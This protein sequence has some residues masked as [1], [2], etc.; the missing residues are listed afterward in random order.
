M[1]K[2]SFKR[3]SI[4]FKII[5]PV[6]ILVCLLF[7]VIYI[8]LIIFVNTVIVKK[9]VLDVQT[10]LEVRNERVT[11]AFNDYSNIGNMIELTNAE[12]LDFLIKN[13]I[14]PSTINELED[15]KKI[16]LVTE[17]TQSIVNMLKRNTATDAF[18]FLDGGSEEDKIGI[19]LRTSN[20]TEYFSD[21]ADIAVE[22]SPYS[23]CDKL[24]SSG[25]GVSQFYETRLSSKLGT[26]LFEKTKEAF[27]A[28]PT[29]QPSLLGY[30][31][32]D[33]YAHENKNFEQAIVKTYPLIIE[34]VYYGVIGVGFT[35]AFCRQLLSLSD[36][37][38]ATNAAYAILNKTGEAFKP[39]ASL[40][41]FSSNTSGEISKYELSKSMYD[42]TLALKYDN[43]DFYAIMSPIKLY[44]DNSP[45]EDEEFFLA[46][47]LDKSFF[48]LNSNSVIRV[49]TFVFV[50]TFLMMLVILLYIS[51]RFVKPIISLTSS[52]R[53]SQALN[54]Y[55]VGIDE[56]DV[57]LAK[58]KNLV[59]YNNDGYEKMRS[60]FETF[61]NEIAIFDYNVVTEKVR[62]FGDFFGIIG[63]DLN[64]IPKEEI[65]V[66]VFRRLIEK[67]A[68]YIF[69]QNNEGDRNSVI[70]KVEEGFGK[71]KYTQ[72]VYIA[73]N[74]GTVGVA[75]DVT[76][77]YQSIETAKIESGIDPLT[78]LL[79]RRGF[80]RVALA[81]QDCDDI[82][83]GAIVMIDLDYLK[84]YND[85]YGH[86]FGDHYIIQF[87]DALNRLKTKK[88]DVV[89]ISGDEFILFYHHYDSME[90][91]KADIT[92]AKE[93][94][95][96]GIVISF[97]D[98]VVTAQSSA[99]VAYYTDRLR[100]Y[101]QL[102]SYADFAMYQ[103]KSKRR[104]RMMEFNKKDYEDNLVV[105]SKIKQ[106]H[107]LLDEELI[108][109]VFQP[110]VSVRTG[111]VLGY[112]ALM[113][114]KIEEIKTPLEILEYAKN[115][116]RLTDLENICITKA[117]KEYSK[118]NCDKPVFINSIASAIISKEIRK[119]I[120]NSLKAER[121]RVIIEM[122][123]EE[124]SSKETIEEKEAI[125]RE[126]GFEYAID[127]YGVG[128]SN[129][130]ALMDMNPT[131]I[132][133]DISLV[134]HVNDS[135]K[136]R[137]IINFLVDF[138]LQN[139]IKLIAEGV[140]NIEQVYELFRL[141]VEYIQG[142]LIAIP[143]Q[144]LKLCPLDLKN[145]I[146]EINSKE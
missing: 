23:V 71:Y 127:D 103:A 56:I 89:H 116:N 34:G 37:P 85:Q 79:N 59:Q 46:I 131:Y 35:S 74:L 24:A 19:Y 119:E 143:S 78:G 15:E 52:V 134:K 104:E 76:N 139:N 18:L 126:Y 84:R 49:L 113:R 129:L 58:I 17:H 96:K 51:R 121:F 5:F 48:H 93:M 94:L 33:Y 22:I 47:V 29:S 54:Y 20:P 14:E 82:Q 25:Y 140:E 10:T 30:W 145:K 28:Y 101:E 12:T 108:Y 21:N 125:M 115:Q 105:L 146:I 107:K 100:D 26:N 142:Y 132:K 9:D 6:F 16:Q 42:N 4:F 69:E 27:K 98:I 57:L 67:R 133:I 44:T 118:L 41:S 60:I 7:V 88:C 38:N 91:L 43:M 31:S 92:V 62:L 77:E 83:N 111:E 81:V 99:G 3:N 130:K 141:G 110:I 109:F 39:I 144:D 114:S 138:S 55:S 66:I 72:L 136:V 137:S 50:P 135:E 68:S 40:S 106:I 120:A 124:L 80:E 11:T 61:S 112:E 86:L 36:Y 65:D 75:T 123:E 32:T 70:Y 117:I 102:V 53:D 8:S 63:L 1:N 73:S 122:T 2:I 64:D 97:N 45:Y 87:G 13:G 95:E 90:K 128:Y